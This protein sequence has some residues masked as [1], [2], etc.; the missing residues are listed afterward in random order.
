MEY[1]EDK[2][3]F[4]EWPQGKCISCGAT[5]QERGAGEEPECL[6]PVVGASFTPRCHCIRQIKCT[7]EILKKIHSDW[8]VTSIAS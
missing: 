2:A 1:A 5:N 6:L 7:R 4:S 8:R 3:V